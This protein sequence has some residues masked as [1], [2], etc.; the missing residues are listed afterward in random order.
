MKYRVSLLP[1]Q[2]R[3][4]LIGKKRLE[5][6]KVYSLVVL[7]VLAVFTFVVLFTSL[8][9]DKKLKEAKKLDNECAQEVAQLEQF[10]EINANLQNK[11]QL[12]ESIQ[13]DEPQLVNFI[14]KVSNLKH[15]GISVT[16]IE[17]TD[18][19]VTRNCVLIGTCDTRAQYL[20]FEEALKE[21]E[22]VSAVACASYTQNVGDSVG[23]QFTINVTC[24]GGA[25]PITTTTEASSETANGESADTTE[26]TELAVE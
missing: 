24:T 21:I 4:R 10:R 18:W 6:I 11:V 3:K 17:C 23:I 19:K 20:A 8:Y 26:A 15:P 2:N 14:A 12:I 1:E 9:A 5:K 25:A 16:S 22:G 13:I 7:V